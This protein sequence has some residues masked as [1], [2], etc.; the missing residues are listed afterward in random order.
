MTSEDA[1]TANLREIE[2]KILAKMEELLELQRL[3]VETLAGLTDSD[4]TK[5][6]TDGNE[7]KNEKISPM[8]IAPKKETIAATVTTGKT[9]D[10]NQVKSPIHREQ[11]TGR[12]SEERPSRLRM[13]F[14]VIQMLRTGLLFE[15]QKYKRAN[16]KE[17][18]EFISSMTRFQRLSTDLANERTLLAWGRTA[19]AAIRTC[20]AYLGLEGVNKFGKDSLN[21]TI[22]GFALLGVIIFIIGAQRYMAIKMVVAMEKPPEHFNR[23]SNYPYLFISTAFLILT[24]ITVAGDDWIK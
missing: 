8:E 18:G 4:Q 11:Y 2:G 21:T 23:L 14:P 12:P 5:P 20:F 7:S 24:V 3:K 10:S 1:R 19:F 6:K 15:D 13:R 9:S 16:E 22:I 17:G